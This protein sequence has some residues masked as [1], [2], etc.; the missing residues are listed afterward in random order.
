MKGD[1]EVF[2]QLQVMFF[3]I[4]IVGIIFFFKRIRNTNNSVVIGLICCVVLATNIS[5]VIIKNIPLPTDDV[6][7]TA[8]GLKNENSLGNE[9]FI[10]NYLIAGEE[11]SIENPSNGKWFWKGDY[12]MWRNENDPRQPS[13]TTRSIT[14][15]IPYGQDRAI[16]FGVS[17]W[18]GLV[19]VTYAGETQTYD[20]Y[21]DGSKNIVQAYVPDTVALSLYFAK[22]FRLLLFIF[23]T[24]LLMLYPVFCV[25]KYDYQQIKFFWSKHWD[26]LIYLALAFGFFIIMFEANKKGSLWHDEVWLLGQGYYDGFTSKTG[27]L[28]NWLYPIWVGIVPYG[29]ENLLALSDLIVALSIYIVGLSGSL[30]GSKRLGIIMSVVLATSTTVMYQCAGEFASYAIFLCSVSLVWY[31]FIKK[32]I[33]FDNPKIYTLILYGISLTICL[34]VHKFGTLTAGFIMVFDLFYLLKRAKVFNLNICE[35]ILPSLYIIYYIIFQFLADLSIAANYS[36]PPAPTLNGALNYIIWLCGDNDILFQLFILGDLIVCLYC[37]RHVL[38]HKFDW[39]KDYIMLVSIIVPILLFIFNFVYSLI[40]NPGNSLF[41]NRYFLS[42]VV[43]FTFIIALALDWIIA[44]I[45]EHSNGELRALNSIICTVFI[46]VSFCLMGWRNVPVDYRDDYKGSADYLMS[47][48][49][50]YNS[51]TLCMVT[52][53]K[54]VDSGFEYYL[55]HKG[56]RDSINHCSLNYSTF[57]D[58]DTVY[59]VY[60]HSNF[61]ENKIIEQGYIEEYSNDSLAIKKYVR[62]D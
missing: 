28:F 25:L 2:F 62:N 21:N 51:S 45:T 41:V 54:Y 15:N 48:N 10:I 27:L 17:Q 58:Y 61:D 47:Q 30:Y 23:V 34:D 53:I 24:L 14:L 4:L 56:K 7:I 16:L 31:F 60:H 36:W 5:N 1:T 39:I 35:F 37:C 6:I 13:G 26:K 50:I 38:L 55:S 19:E 49:D 18:S 9:V 33:E 57:L 59:V 32:Q 20:L 22:C 11:Q 3:I 52:A 8:T 12:Y 46:I 29:Q 42:C 44:C 43:F 40:I